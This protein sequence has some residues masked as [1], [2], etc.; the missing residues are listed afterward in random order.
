MQT[1]QPIFIKN[2][3]IFVPDY[4]QTYFMSTY[5]NK[6]KIIATIGPATS[7]K[8][9]LK[10]L[11]EAGVNVCRL[12]FS[13]GSHKDHLEV[14][15]YILELNEEL[16]TN[17]ALLADL[18]GP[19]LRIGE[20][21]NN[22]IE[23]IEGHEIE[24]INTPCVGNLDRVYMSYPLFASDVAIGDTVLIDDGK[25]KLEVTA[26]NGK[27][28]VKAKVIFGGILSSKK[29]V[30]LPKTIISLPSMTEKDLADAEF[31]LNH[32]VDWL[33][34]SFVRCAEDI[35]A[36]RKIVDAKGKHTGIIA[37][38]EKPEAL[39]VIDDIIEVSDGIM[40]AR[41]DLGVELHFSQVPLKQKMIVD[42]CI[43]FAKP[44][45]IATQMMESMITNFSPTRAE[46][47]DVA[48]AVIDGTSTVMLSGE[49]SVGKYPI[50][51]IK[52]MSN[53]ISDAE[54][55]GYKYHRIQKPI[56]E[57]DTFILDS[58]CHT[59]ANMAIQMN[60]NS[61]AVLTYT[62][63]SVKKIASYRPKANIY[64]FTP[65]AKIQRQLSLIWGV[66]AFLSN[67][68]MFTNDAVEFTLTTL[69]NRSK[70][71]AGELVISVG[72]LPLNKKGNTNMVKIS[73][74]Q[75]DVINRPY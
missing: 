30:N 63:S 64:V 3:R 66:Q 26:T 75:E 70:I 50:E 61:I 17:I 32:D 34:L 73:Y 14:I 9:Q 2:S 18:Q 13:H 59:A 37:K 72:T 45:I 58:T 36:L 29:G 28:T 49:T 71:D 41:G 68:F 69:F 39:D 60:T 4:K 7:S 67:D 74:Y 52:A 65:N 38:I 24:F 62:G 35:I 51:V 12:N 44:V 22:G 57:K 56:I 40:V 43:H 1:K 33:A 31:A 47:N 23:L 11:F 16:G 6:T 10:K 54:Q 42:R 19:K 48:N 8:E 15:N 27:D 46:A 53:I 55:F 21:E 25:L 20:V 5:I